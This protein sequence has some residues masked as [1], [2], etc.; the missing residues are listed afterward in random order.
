MAECEREVQGGFP[1]LS[2][3]PHSYVI[4]Y[5][6][7][8]ES[9]A[10]EQQLSLLQSLVV[11]STDEA[12]LAGR[13]LSQPELNILA[14]YDRARTYE[15]GPRRI[16]VSKRQ[17]SNEFRIDRRALREQLKAA[18]TLRFGPFKSLGKS[19]FRYRTVV[20][21]VTVR[22]HLDVGG[23]TRQFSYWHD[24]MLGDCGYV[25][26][27]SARI[28]GG[29]SFLATLGLAGSTDW[30]YLTQEEIP[31]AVETVSELCDRLLQAV[32]ILL[33]GFLDASPVS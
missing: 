9:W 28:V 17:S 11:R 20:S 1:L 30:E 15:F 7:L 12:V 21:G 16:D 18:L 25:G 24:L 3:I 5:L 31:N 6:E 26:N 14:C 22:L 8:V 29:L 23:T 13:I 32:P 27:E 10:T 19:E 33:D 2:R 4:S